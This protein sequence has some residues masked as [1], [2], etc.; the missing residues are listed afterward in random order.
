MTN[1]LLIL[2]RKNVRMMMIMS[3]CPALGVMTKSMAKLRMT[4]FMV[5]LETT[6][7][8]EEQTLIGALMSRLKPTVRL[9]N[10]FESTSQPKG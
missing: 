3:L 6:L 5:E 2:K 9:E 4:F 8:M 10:Y 1:S 7:V